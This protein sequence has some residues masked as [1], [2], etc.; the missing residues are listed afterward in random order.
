MFTLFQNIR[1]FGI[2]FA[3]FPLLSLAI[4]VSVH[5][6]DDS[7]GSS[8]GFEHVPLHDVS[9]HAGCPPVGCTG[10]TLCALDTQRGPLNVDVENNEIDSL[11]DSE[12][13]VDAF[14][15]SNFENFN[16]ING[17]KPNNPHS[18]NSWV[19]ALLSRY[20]PARCRSRSGLWPA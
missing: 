16:L 11:K 19:M 15:P 5:S 1:I 8:H 4:H 6:D 9:F 17:G 7:S 2:A 14:S 20:L 13:I 18:T 12:W 10:S 3:L